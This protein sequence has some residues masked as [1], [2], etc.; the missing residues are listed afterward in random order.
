MHAPG[1]I[2]P[3][4]GTLVPPRPLLALHRPGA[5]R[6]A[7]G[8]RPGIRIS[9]HL[10]A[11]GFAAM[12]RCPTPEKG[13]ERLTC[14]RLNLEPAA[15]LQGLQRSARAS[16]HLLHDVCTE[17]Y[18][19]GERYGRLLPYMRYLHEVFISA[20]ILSSCGTLMSEI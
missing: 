15:T 3:S 20:C 11:A 6:L 18:D 13:C 4:S 7:A 16:P 10:T 12:Y 17:S 5:P 1:G 14:M 2:T 8:N 9:G 19:H